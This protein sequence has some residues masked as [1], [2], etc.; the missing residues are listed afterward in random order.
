[1][2]LPILDLPLAAL[3][4]T[5]FVAGIAR[6]LSGFGTGMIVAPV[7]GALFGPAPALAILTLIDILPTI[8]VTLPVMRI[9]RWREIL[10]VFCGLLVLYPL[11]IYLVIHADVMMLRWLIAAAIFACVA[12]LASGYRYRGPRNTVTSFGV[13]GMAGVLSGIAAIPGPPILAYWLASDYPA[14]IVRANLLTL[15]LI[16]NLVSGPNIWFAGLFRA[17]VV[18]I[19]LVSMPPYFVGL[20]IGWRFFGSASESAYRRITFA[21]ILLAAFLALPLFDGIF[22]GLA[23]FLQ[24]TG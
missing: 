3:L 2:P 15:F 18:M 20:L 17:D 21:L 11:G 16:S 1:M 8:P 12:V 22:V 23:A 10:P 4:V 9:A 7:A 6:G 5:V 14:K 13:G 19:G 24:A